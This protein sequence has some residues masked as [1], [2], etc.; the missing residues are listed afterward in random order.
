MYK[1]ILNIKLKDEVPIE[2][3]RSKTNTNDIRKTL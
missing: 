2:E 1:I 3:I